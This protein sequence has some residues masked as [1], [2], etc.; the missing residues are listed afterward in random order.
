MDLDKIRIKLEKQGW[1]LEKYFLENNQNFLQDLVD[2]TEKAI[3]YTRCSTQF[4]CC[5]EAIEQRCNEQCLG[6]YTYKRD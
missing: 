5:K 6:C 4:F 2:E 3:N 1:K